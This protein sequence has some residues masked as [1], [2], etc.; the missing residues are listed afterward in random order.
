MRK[1]K[2]KGTMAINCIERRIEWERIGRELNGL[3][4]ASAMR[5]K[6]EKDEY[7]QQK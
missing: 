1:G 4:N 2:G 3:Y 5:R 7:G 6:G